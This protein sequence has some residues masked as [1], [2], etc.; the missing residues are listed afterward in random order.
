MD[1]TTRAVAKGLISAIQAEAEGQH[2]Y[3]MAARTTEDEKGR[4]VFEQLAAEEADHQR[5]LRAQYEALLKT[6]KPDESITLGKRLDLSGESPIFSPQL[7]A[8]VKDA[9]FEMTALSI[10]VQLELSAINHYRECAAQSGD[11]TVKRFFEELA[12]W[13]NGH[14]RALLQQQDELRDDYWEASGFAPF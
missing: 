1:H 14:Y 8:R 12:A 10:G 7:K 2:F 4:Q 5:F 6:G 13:E 9:H 3:L 11:S